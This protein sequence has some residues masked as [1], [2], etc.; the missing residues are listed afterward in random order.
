MSPR[1]LGLI[2]AAAAA[3]LDIGSKYWLLEVFDIRAR[4]PLHVAPF[5]DIVMV[6]NKGISYSL[7]QAHTDMARWA[8]FGFTVV[9]TLALAIWMWRAN[10]RVLTL[11]LGL[12]VGGAIGNAADRAIHGAVADFFHFFLDTER[13]G[14]LSWY[15][16]NIADVAIVAGVALLLYDSLRAKSDPAPAGENSSPS[17]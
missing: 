1:Q 11:G 13:W 4:Q 12:I 2:A 14:R 15:V 9:A 16:F 6:W 17:A 3:V 7:F 10:D 5:F 8:L